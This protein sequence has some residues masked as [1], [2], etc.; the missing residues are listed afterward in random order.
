MKKVWKFIVKILTSVKDKVFSLTNAIANDKLKHVFL[1][2]CIS[3]IAVNGFSLLFKI[4]MDM[5]IWGAVIGFF[6]SLLTFAFKEE[7]LDANGK[8]T[9]DYN[10]FFAGAFSSTLVLITFFTGILT[11]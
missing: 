9:Q 8:G 3:F 4:W 5:P 10:D 7:K 2:L 6:L 1:G 11:N